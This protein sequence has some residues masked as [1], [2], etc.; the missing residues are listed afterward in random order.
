MTPVARPMTLFAAP[1][2]LRQ[3]HIDQ[4]DPGSLL[5]DDGLADGPVK[6]ATDTLPT[7]F[8]LPHV[9]DRA[10]PGS[11]DKPIGLDVIRNGEQKR[12]RE[13]RTT[14]AVG[15]DRVSVILCC[16]I[17]WCRP[18]MERIILFVMPLARDILR[19]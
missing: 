11:G 6:A 13:G 18:E 2:D 16:T 15:D 12:D 4:D 9:V 3:D 8:H 17:P 5:N 10:E 7:S 1:E 14:Y 19:W